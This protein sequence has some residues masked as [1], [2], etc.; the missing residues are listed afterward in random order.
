MARFDPE[1]RA[2]LRAGIVSLVIGLTLMAGK[3]LAYRITGSTAIFSDALES[4]VNVLAAVFA[5]GSILF[6]GRPADRGHPYGHGKIEFFSAI[7][8]GGLIS[9]AA[10]AIAYQAIVS[11]LGQV[12]LR[13]LNAGLAITAVAGVINGLLGWYLV[14]VGRRTRSMILIADGKHVLSDVWT[15]AGVLAGLGLVLLTG[16]RWLD[17][18]VALVV[19]V[20]LGRTGFLLVQ[21]AARALLDEEDPEL[22]M[23]ILSAGEAVR[24]PGIIRL[25][26]LRAIR[27]G[28]FV[29]VD[30]HVVVPEFWSVLHSHE[31]TDAF[32]AAVLEKCSIDGEILFHTDPCRQLYC[33]ACDLPECPVRREEFT[34][35][36]RLTLEE[37][38]IPDP[39]KHQSSIEAVE[40]QKRS[41]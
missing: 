22:L 15:T 27:V 16:Q 26:H 10:V 32:E 1:N 20:H 38:T 4:I 28:S 25:H 33:S 23:E 2:R 3:F 12:E 18:I 11:L 39:P 37:A 41:P 8:E 5:L 9:F 31:H 17:P 19:A 6:A 35:R 40:E 14:R 30:A 29:H 36:P 24:F 7:F 21:E 13:Q 34:E